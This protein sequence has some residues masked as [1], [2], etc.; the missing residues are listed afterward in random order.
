MRMM[1][2]SSES[3]VSIT[4]IF[5]IVKRFFCFQ[6]IW[7][8]WVVVADHGVCMCFY[9]L[10]FITVYPLWIQKFFHVYERSTSGTL[11]DIFFVSLSSKFWSLSHMVDNWLVNLIRADQIRSMDERISCYKGE[12]KKTCTALLRLTSYSQLWLAQPHKLTCGTSELSQLPV[13]WIKDNKD[14]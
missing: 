6:Q 9:S 8:L 1:I 14:L 12:W 2:I 7:N 13:Q 4:T 5:T 11:H 3:R 10:S